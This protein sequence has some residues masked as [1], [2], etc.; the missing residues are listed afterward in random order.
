MNFI[1]TDIPEVVI[2]EPKV[3]SDERGYFFESYRHDL[4]C[5]N[6]ANIEWL[7]ENESYSVYGTLRGLHYQL[8]PYAQSKLVRVIDG[9]VLDVAVDIRRKSPTFGKYVSIE[10]SAENKR[11]LFIPRGFAHGFVVL[12]ERAIFQYKVDNYYSKESEGAICFNDPTLG[13]N[14]GVPHDKIIISEKDKAASTFK[15]ARVFE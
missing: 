14:W 8:P 7:Q 6:V 5:A 9:K 3:W 11:E 2:I 12:S 15:D 1:K 4:F 13:I 10:L